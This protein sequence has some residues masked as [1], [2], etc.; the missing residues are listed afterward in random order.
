MFG[1]KAFA[2]LS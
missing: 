2:R 1:F